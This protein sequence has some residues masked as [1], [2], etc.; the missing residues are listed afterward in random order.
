MSATLCRSADVSSAKSPTAA[1][2]AAGETPALLEKS[3]A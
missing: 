3:L 2:V 1:R